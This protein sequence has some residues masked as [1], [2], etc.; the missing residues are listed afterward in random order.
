MQRRF[1]TFKTMMKKMTNTENL[2]QKQIIIRRK[3]R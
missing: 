1:K 2:A 3:T